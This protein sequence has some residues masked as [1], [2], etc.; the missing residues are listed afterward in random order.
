MRSRKD[1]GFKF[2]INS[3]AAIEKISKKNGENINNFFNNI[4]LEFSKYV[5]L[6][7]GISN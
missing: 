7:R 4:E 5:L 3:N 1:L 2:L 6:A